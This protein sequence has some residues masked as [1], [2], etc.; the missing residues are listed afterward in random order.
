MPVSTTSASAVFCRATEF[1]TILGA[2]VFFHL[3]ELEHHSVQFDVT[4][5]AGEIVFDEELRQS[6]DLK[7][8]GKAELLPNTLGE[9]R[10]RGHLQI[11][12][13][14]PCDRCLEPA[15]TSLDMDFDLFYRPQPKIEGHPEIRIEEGETDLSFYQGDKLELEEV[16]REFILLQ[17]PMRRVCRPDCKGLC[18]QC[19]KNRNDGDCGCKSTIIADRWAALKNL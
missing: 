12:M 2:A 19:G 7:A 11:S 18:P 13:E 14:G 1:G 8:V 5:G 6:G 16:L 3:T 9:I 4:Y 17:M 15:G 10:V